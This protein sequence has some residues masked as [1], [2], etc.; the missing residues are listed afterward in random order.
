[1]IFFCKEQRYSE[2]QRKQHSGSVSELASKKTATNHDQSHDLV[3]SSSVQ[4]SDEPFKMF[5]ILSFHI[6]S[7]LP[8]QSVSHK[9]RC[10]YRENEKRV[11]HV[12]PPS[13]EGIDVRIL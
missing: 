13:C 7:P 4:I 3:V 1:M 11:R 8:F 10:I 5:V 6:H 9:G 12:F 2:H